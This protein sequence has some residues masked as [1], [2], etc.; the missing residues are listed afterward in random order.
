ML[1]NS[2]TLFTDNIP[3]SDS[4]VEIADLKKRFS[5]FDPYYVVSACIPDRKKWFDDIWNV[6]YPYANED[7]VKQYKLDFH[8]RTWEMY[9]GY[10]LLKNKYSIEVTKKGPDFNV[11]NLHYIECIACN[12]AR[13]NNKPDFVP[14]IING[15]VNNYPKNEILLRIASAFYT[16]YCKYKKYLN[17]NTIENNKPCII[18]INSG[19]FGR[20]TD[21]FPPLIIQMLF[22]I[23][24][25]CLNFER[26]G[27][28]SKI[29]NVEFIEKKNVFKGNIL[30]EMNYFC[31]NSYKEI[32]AVIFSRNNVLNNINSVG[33]DCVMVRNPYAINPLSLDDYSFLKCLTLEDFKF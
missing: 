11:N 15:L 20:L 7:F 22:G 26:T 16:K 27:S 13:F 31:N 17:Q 5:N 30:I 10:I 25:L 2:Q 28:S 32:S 33:S 4:N 21:D 6:F 23:G 1:Q 9:L 24:D 12:N 18:A 19:K 8:Q 14:P 3:F 29:K